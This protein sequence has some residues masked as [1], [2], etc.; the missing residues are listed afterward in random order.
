[1]NIDCYAPESPNI[2]AASKVAGETGE[3]SKSTTDEPSIPK[4]TGVELTLQVVASDT[5]NDAEPRNRAK[6]QTDPKGDDDRESRLRR[7]VHHKVDHPDVPYER[8]AEMYKIPKTTIQRHLQT[9]VKSKGG[10][11]AF[12]VAQ[13]KMFENHLLY[14]ADQVLPVG[15]AQFL[16]YIKN[17]CTQFHIN[18]QRFKNG[19]PGK[20]WLY[21][22]MK[23][24][25][26]L[27]AR[28]A[29]AMTAA[30]A[31]GTSPEKLREFF[32]NMRPSLDPS[33]ANY[34]QPECVV[35]Y[36]ETAMTDSAGDPFVITRRST[37]SP[38]IALNNHKTN[39]SV[40]FA[41]TADGKVLA[42]Y[43]CTKTKFKAQDTEAYPEC[44]WD[45]SKSG[46]FN[47][48]V[49]DRWF[50][51]VIV[52]W[53][54]THPG[55]RKLVIGDAL[56]AH[57]SPKTYILAG[58]EG[59][60]FFLLPPNST[61]FLQPLD[62]AVFA[63]LKRAWKKALLDYKMSESHKTLLKKD[64]A[65]LLKEAVSAIKPETVLASFRTT[66]L[67]PFNPEIAVKRLPASSH[68]VHDTSG[69]VLASA[70]A[71]IQAH[72]ITPTKKR[73][74]KR[75]TPGT[76]LSIQ[77]QADELSSQRPVTQ[78]PGLSTQQANE[79]APH[80]SVK[81]QADELSSQQPVAQEPGLSTQQANEQAPQPSV[82]PQ[83]DE[84][85]SPQPETQEPEL[86]TQQANEQAPQPSIQTQADKQA[87]IQVKP[88]TKITPKKRKKRSDIGCHPKRKRSKSK[89]SSD[90]PSTS[91]PKK[92]LTVNLGDQVTP[93]EFPDVFDN[94][95]LKTLAKFLS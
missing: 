94:I 47:M 78:E 7:A 46:W 93:E 1:M 40:M 57:F 58:E 72:R 3:S 66:G 88:L 11:T 27:Q 8:I 60:Q 70:L 5:E 65:P 26:D 63:P 37:K 61:H 64:F 12:S 84:L 23:R 39:R 79:Q 41:V 89:K 83:A 49:F 91:S 81:P 30:K 86:S 69:S 56:P 13:E 14:C 21:G 92:H 28:R 10:Q 17:L 31:W 74:D 34:C 77:P 22:F 53:A 73:V 67:V 68:P 52:P 54:K 15:Q 55:K 6:V 2:Q 36:D 24:H 95:P 16:D 32:E 4:S 42:P 80:V 20:D 25:P 9:N 87:E 45:T 29:K 51:T 71:K 59:I 75:P 48:E 50:Q 90:S 18:T 38:R 76:D 44:H 19:R 33:G 43:V 85:S 35:N 62:V 82:Q